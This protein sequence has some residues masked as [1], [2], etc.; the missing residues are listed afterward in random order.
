MIPILYDGLE[1]EFENQGIGRLVDALACVVREER[2][3]AYEL[4]MRYPADGPLFGELSEGRIISAT[5]DM[6]GDRQP[7][8]IYGRSASIDGIV[9]VYAHHI[10]YELANVIL[11]PFTA[12]SLSNLRVMFISRVIAGVDRA[13]SFFPRFNVATPFTTAIP[14]SE[15]EILLGGDTSVVS[16]YGGE[17]DY[18]NFNVYLYEKRG[19]D[20]GVVIRYGHNLLDL[21][22]ETDALNA[23]SAVVPFWTDGETVVIGDVCYGDGT[24]SRSSVYWSNERNY[25]ISTES[26]QDIEFGYS[27]HAAVTMDLSS[28]FKEAPTA[29]QLEALALE[30][31]NNSTPWLK[32]ETLTIDYIDL[33]QTNEFAGKNVVGDIHLC[34]TVRIVC[35][36]INVDT[37][38]QVVATNYDVLMDRFEAI[39]VGSPFPSYAEALSGSVEFRALTDTR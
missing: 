6:D 1:T 21:T 13:F 12:T 4:E 8:V 16:V 26:G 5:H 15:R 23:Y 2:N 37:S 19:T 39:E 7:F 35:P 32:K 22:A 10:S 3:G 38:A 34:D 14:M 36:N 24:V 28:D 17:L 11:A 31:L 33:N 25:R 18:D 20:N 30:R 27:A 9:T 29:A